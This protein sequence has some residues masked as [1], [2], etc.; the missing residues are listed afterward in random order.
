M[1]SF[2]TIKT[3]KARISEER[4]SKSANK[5]CRLESGSDNV[6][7]NSEAAEELYESLNRNGENTTPCG[8]LQLWADVFVDARV[9][10]S[11]LQRKHIDN[12]L[13]CDM[14]VPFTIY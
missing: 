8:D 2:S 13:I 5:V 14:D 12:K 11:A 9:I 10:L 1:P 3:P 4:S 6:Q 7:G